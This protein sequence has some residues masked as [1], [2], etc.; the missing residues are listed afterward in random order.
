MLSDSVSASGNALEVTLLIGE[1]S[2]EVFRS[3][4]LT[5][6]QL[7]I[8]AA[9]QRHF[10]VRHVEELLQVSLQNSS[11]FIGPTPGSACEQSWQGSDAL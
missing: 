10:A 7:V 2:G 3:W 8:P 1:C 6:P 9:H 11:L 4:A 5:A